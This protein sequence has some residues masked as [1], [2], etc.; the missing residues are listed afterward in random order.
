MGPGDGVD[1]ELVEVELGG[2]V[3]ELVADLRL[4]AD[5]VAGE[6][7]GFGG[8]GIGCGEAEDLLRRG[9]GGELAEGFVGR[10]DGAAVVHADAAL[11]EADAGVEVVGLLLGVGD[12]GDDGDGG[13]RVR[14]PGAGLEVLL[15]VL[16]GGA[17]GV[18]GEEVGEGVGQ[19]VGGGGD[20]GPHGRA[21]EPE[22]GRA[23]RGGRDAEICEG[24][25]LREE[26]LFGV[27]VGE[28]LG[29]LLREVVGGGAGADAAQGLRF[30][31]AAAGGAADAEVDAVGVERVQGAEDFGDLEGRVVREHDAAG[32]DADAL[33]FGADAGEEDLRR[34]AGERVHGVVLGVPEAM[35]AEGVDMA[36]EG[37]GVLQSFAGRAAGGDGG[38]V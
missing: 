7:A 26:V 28:E 36:G 29:E 15:V 35:E 27:E 13:F 23:E 14:A 33:G 17:G 18:A 9:E 32:A 30:D 12:D 24:M 6:F 2:D 20:G 3:G 38:L 25:A 4:G 10:G 21:E 22:V 1:D 16:D 19:A 34:G 37:D 8:V 31:G 11:E 5:D